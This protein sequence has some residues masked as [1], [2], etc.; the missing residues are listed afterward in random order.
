ME[1]SN[2][3]LELFRT[4]QYA[5]EIGKVLSNREIDL[6]I[7]IGCRLLAE[8]QEVLENETYHEVGLSREEVILDIERIEYNLDEFT[9]AFMEKEKAMVVMKYDKPMFFHMN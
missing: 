3:I 4:Q 8:A 1:Q 6:Y 7:S 5:E 2:E 9:D